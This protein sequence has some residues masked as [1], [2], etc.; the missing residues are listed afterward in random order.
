MGFG[1]SRTTGDCEPRHVVAVVWVCTGL[2]VA[3]LL[4]LR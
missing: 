4:S 2:K 1:H 3:L